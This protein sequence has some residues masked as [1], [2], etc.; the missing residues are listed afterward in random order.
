MRNRVLKRLAIVPAVALPLLAG[1]SANNAS[2]S[3]AAQTAQKQKALGQALTNI[4]QNPYMPPAAKEAA[5]QSL[6][7]HQNVDMSP[8]R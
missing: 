8:R 7:A 5:K 4:D 3:P 6:V 2:P 1:C